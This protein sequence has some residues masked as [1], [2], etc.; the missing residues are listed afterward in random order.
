MDKLLLKLSYL[1]THIAE[2]RLFS[3]RRTFSCHDNTLNSPV[4]VVM[5]VVN[6]HRT[7]EAT[8]IGRGATIVVNEVTFAPK[9]DDCLM[10][11]I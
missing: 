11:G 5:K 7:T 1:L 10:V 2:G 6:A 4:G 3:R 9:V 8:A